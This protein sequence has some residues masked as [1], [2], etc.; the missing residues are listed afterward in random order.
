M[1]AKVL[2]GSVLGIE[3]YIVEVEVDISGGLPSFATVGLPEGAVRESKER[4]KAAI[5]NSGYELPPRKITVNLAPA[6]V[7]KEGSAFDLPI[8]VGILSALGLISPQSLADRL[9][10]GELSLDGAV[11]PV[12][13]GL[14][15]AVA[16][17]KNELRGIV[18]PAPNAREAAV[19]DGLQVTPVKD[20]AQVV[21]MLRGEREVTPVKVS[22]LETIRGANQYDEDFRDVK[23]QEHAKRALEVAAAG[24][25]NIL[26]IYSVLSPPCLAVKGFSYFGNP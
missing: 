9:F 23:G 1:L 14:P 22:V 19:V 21:S 18:M 25:H 4:V 6:D 20:L 16:A 8:A 13:G 26:N 12:R 11:K 3:G 17:R 7:K 10:L 5:K 2:S 24:G 15:M